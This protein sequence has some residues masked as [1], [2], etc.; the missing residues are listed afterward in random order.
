MSKPF[1][2]EEF[3]GGKPAVIGGIT[4]HFLAYDEQLQYPLVVRNGSFFTSALLKQFEENATM[5]PTKRTVWIAIIKE[6]Q[7]GRIMPSSHLYDSKEQALQYR[8]A[9]WKVIDAIP[10]EIEE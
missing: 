2:F 10:Y 9:M 3:K 1:N 6:N 5:L 7:N 4:Y 8:A